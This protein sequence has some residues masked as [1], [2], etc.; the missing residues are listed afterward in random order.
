MKFSELYRLLEENGW[1]K[2]QGKKHTKYVHPD[3]DKPVPVGRHPGKEVPKGT[4][5]AILKE[6]GLK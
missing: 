1:Q 4:L 2:K 3:F 5:E 6:A